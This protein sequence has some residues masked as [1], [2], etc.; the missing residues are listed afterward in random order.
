MSDWIAKALQQRNPHCG[1]TNS[2]AQI[3]ARCDELHSQGLKPTQRNIGMVCMHVRLYQLVRMW[4]ESHGIKA[5]ARR[6]EG[7]GHNG[8][9]GK[10][11]ELPK[12]ALA[13]VDP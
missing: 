3:L 13:G 2:D 4:K 5:R 12:P 8:H 7:T 6:G 10:R 11:V 1:P 9:H